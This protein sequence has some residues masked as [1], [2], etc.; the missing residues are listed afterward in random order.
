M[1]EANLLDWLAL[2]AV[3]DL[4]PARGIKLINHFG[5]PSLVLKARQ[6]E[7][8]QVDG[9]GQVLA[10]KIT[11]HADYKFAENQLL[12]LQASP[13]K[14]ITLKSPE[15]PEKLKH[16]YD[17]PLFF[18]AHGDLKCLEKPTIAM[19]GS[20]S[21]SVYGKMMTEKLAT[22]LAQ[23]GFTTVSG[24]ARGID[25]IAHKYTIDAGGQTA[26]VFGSGLDVIYPPENK[27][28]YKSLVL[29]GCAISE[30][31]L[32]TKPDPYNFP[33]RNRI[34]SGL[35]LGVLVIEA[36][37]RSG[38]LLTV[39]HALDQNRE[40]FAVP[41]NVN[42]KTSQGTNRIIKEGAK[43]VTSA[44]DILEEFKFLVAP[45][46][47]VDDQKIYEKLTKEQKKIYD[48]LSNEPI[49][50]D[51]IVK[52]SG[53]A[54]SGALEILLDLELSSYVRQLSGKMFVKEL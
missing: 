16:I 43:L 11:T 4:G 48:V 5:S 14:L 3:P 44:D 7:L 53:L 12:K 33:R 41:G 18:F 42:S 8:L 6:Q 50:L 54:V 30:F 49:Q 28:L 15:Y 17:P 1:S 46:E 27:V 38:A 36:A 22:E 19:V 29:N 31:Y 2:A 37:G 13:Y 32:G 39:Q 47:I 23:V 51:N 21:L 34:I 35:C 9:I 52:K 20:R 26:A 40:V 24:F 45:W 10:K 25:T